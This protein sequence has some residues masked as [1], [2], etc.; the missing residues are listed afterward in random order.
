MKIIQ[1]TLSSIL[2][3]EKKLVKFFQLLMEA[4][5]LSLDELGIKSEQQLFK[6]VMNWAKTEQQTDLRSF[7]ENQP[8]FIRFADKTTRNSKNFCH[9]NPTVGGK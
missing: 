3:S 2:D 6:K 7:F 1:L 5:I 4:Q 9:W 8:K